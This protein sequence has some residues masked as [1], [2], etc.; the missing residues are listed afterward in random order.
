MSPPDLPHAPSPLGR[1]A[2][3]AGALSLSAAAVTPARGAEPAFRVLAEGLRF[4]EGPIPLPGGDVLVVEIAR[5]TLT[6]VRP[7]RPPDVVAE[8]GGGPNGAAIGPDGACYV[9][10]NGGFAWAEH[11]GLLLPAGRAKDNIGGRIQR[12]DLKTGQVTT[13]LTEVEGRPLSAPNDLVF[14]PGGGLWFT[15]TGQDFGRT[16][17]MG[18]L[19][20]TR[21]DGSGARAAAPSL[22]TPNGVALSPDRRTLYVASTIERQIVAFDILEG[23]RVAPG[24]GM[25]PGRVVA[26]FPGRMLL[27]SIAV[28]QDGAIVAATVVEGGLVVVRPTG[29][30]VR[31]I[32]LPDLLTTN[33]AF[34]GPGRRT[35]Y[36]TLGATGRLIA[37]PWPAAGLA[38]LFQPY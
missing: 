21:P 17:E 30:V 4:P 10:N 8:L 1:R 26:S 5:G 23:G 9:C 34:G 25:L 36:V 13:V 19:C 12:V 7:G 20:W 6:R 33:I 27:D 11:D 24:P 32:R 18:R 15:D 28:Q 14:E 38:R 37:M 22:F 35:A 2:L 16:R 3:L 31:R 29:E